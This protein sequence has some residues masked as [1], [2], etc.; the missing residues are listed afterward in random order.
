[1]RVKGNYPAPPIPNTDRVS[2]VETRMSATEVDC[3][4]SRD[5]EGGSLGGNG[6]VKKKMDI[7]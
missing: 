7:N 2:S 4:N 6:I 1:M 3:S 5:G